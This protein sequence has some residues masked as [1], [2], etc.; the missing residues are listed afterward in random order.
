MKS[1]PR[2]LIGTADLG[3]NLS[4]MLIIGSRLV[5]DGAAVHVLGHP[6]QRAAVEAAGLVFTAYT[7]ARTYPPPGRHSSLAGVLGLIHLVCD[8]GVGVDLVELATRERSDVLLVDN[9]LLAGLRAGRRSGLPTVALVH[10]LPAFYT[11]QWAH[12]PIGLVATLRGLRPATVWHDLAG[13]ITVCL[14]E[15]VGT[16]T[17]LGGPVVGPV[18]PGTPHRTRPGRPRALLGLSTFPWP[19]MDTVAQRI[20]DAVSPMD[21]DVVFTTGPSLDPIDLTVPNNVEM[22]RYI[23]HARL[24]PDVDLMIAHGGHGTTMR[25]LAHDLPLLMVPLHPMGDQPAIA[26]AITA[27]GAG[28]TLPRTAALPTIRAAIDQLLTQPQFSNAAA[29]LGERIRARD[30]AG[31][32]SAYLRRLADREQART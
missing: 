3:G 4:P 15:L 19:G 10:S 30:P 17:A 25:A 22:H 29:H 14:P 1:A 26:R 24:M 13:A 12:S 6:A 2:I 27:H 18:W 11:G 20:L 9:M 32:A 8:S 31:V 16:D 23:D 21:I 7:R 5:A 28:I